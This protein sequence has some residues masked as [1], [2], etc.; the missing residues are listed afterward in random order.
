M[1]STA[2]SHIPMQ[3]TAQPRG[4]PLRV[5]VRGVGLVEVMIALLVLSI[6]LLGVANLQ[7]SG[8]R[9]TQEAYFHSQAAVL[10]Q[11]IIDRMRANPSA[12]GDDA[13]L[14]SSFAEEE[15]APSC[16]P[17][18]LDGSVAQQDLALWTQ[19]LACALPAGDGTVVRRDDGVMRIT[20]RWRTREDGENTFATETTEVQL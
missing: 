20:V 17:V 6:G 14:R 5:R 2:T 12:A 16:A 15:K 19:R 13:Y 4:M 10:A 3:A 9:M 7:L 18:M 1:T 8:L 11:D